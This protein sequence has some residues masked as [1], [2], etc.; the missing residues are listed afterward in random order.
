MKVDCP[1]APSLS[2]EDAKFEAQK[3]NVKVTAKNTKDVSSYSLTGKK[4]SSTETA[5]NLDFNCLT[6]H[7]PETDAADK[8]VFRTPGGTEEYNPYSTA[9]SNTFEFTVHM[10]TKVNG[11]EKEV[12]GSPCTASVIISGITAGCK[13]NDNSQ[14]FSIALQVEDPFFGQVQ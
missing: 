11:V 8:L 3:F 7:C 9:G 5:F 4:N 1:F 12:E 2:C 13:W 10:K 14:T 6:D